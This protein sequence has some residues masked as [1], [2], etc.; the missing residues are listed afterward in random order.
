MTTAGTASSPRRAVVLGGGG[1]TGI[2]WEV[3]LLA[4]LA[5]A[6]V[7]LTAADAVFGTS[8]G[9]FVGVALAGGH[10]LEALFAVQSQP[11]ATEV[12]SSA[13]QEV[14]IAW[15]E[16]YTSGGSDPRAVGAAFGAIGRAHPE[17]VPLAARRAVVAARLVTGTWPVS[18][19]VTAIDANTG[20]LEVFDASCGVALL[21][22][23][24]ASGAVPGVWPLERFGGR[25]WVDGGMVSAANAR[26]AD[27]YDRVLVIA[28]LPDG[29]GELPGA[30]DDVA[31][32]NERAQVLL[33]A[34]DEASVAA[35][36][37]NI[38]DPSRRGA[39]AAAGR[40]Q[41]DAVA[42]ALASVW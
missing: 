7:D 14:L 19:H 30:A 38:Y 4:G 9:A 35:V 20:A 13:S 42:A 2:A 41:A 8:A 5:A 12:G 28:P 25:S 34:P 10:D 23:V 24:A 29:Y 32:M 26:L 37:P 31:V 39:A 18:L 27:G 15:Y 22:A 21:D 40:E 6:G 11:P 17:P 36:G 3:G 16:A 1:V 33:V